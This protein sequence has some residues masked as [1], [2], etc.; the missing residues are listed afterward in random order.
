MNN[1]LKLNCPDL[2]SKRLKITQ[3]SK[4]RK[5]QISSNLLALNGFEKG[6]AVVETPLGEGKG[7]TV[8]L[9]GGIPF[10]NTKRIYERS[11]KQRKNNP[12]EVY[13]ETSSK[14]ILDATIPLM[15]EIVHVTITFGRIIVKP[16]L[17]IIAE[18]LNQ[19]ARA[20][21]PFTVF[22]ACSSGVDA[23]AAKSAGFEINSLL[24]Y[25][26]QE[27]RD[28]RDLTET[29]VMCALAN[30]NPKHVFNEDI[31][32]VSTQYLEWATKKD[33][34]SVFTISLQCDDFSS[35]KSLTNRQK[36]ILNLTSTLDMAFDGLRIISAL[37]FP[38]VVLEQVA[39]F[40]STDIARMWD[41][42]LRK[43][44]Y[45]THEII[46]DARDYGGITS[47]NR[48]FHVSTMIPKEFAFSFPE[49]T[50]RR[51]TPIWDEYIAPVLNDLREIT[52]TSSMQKGL[53]CGR[54]RIINS[55]KTYSYSILKSQ[56]RQAKDSLV[57]ADGNRILFPNEALLKSLMSI[58]SDFN[59]NAT[60]AEQ[61]TE[62]IGQAVEYD[63]YKHLMTSIKN[64]IQ[65]YLDSAKSSIKK[66]VEPA[67]AQ[68]M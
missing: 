25:R 56:M 13:F 23:H 5:I 62:I 43:M 63:F 6:T 53:E 22:A 16:M 33:P 15:T 26:P 18:K 37:K 20:M 40:A 39:S 48:Y 9:A 54:L 3:T 47:R 49:M 1:V 55:T 34:S 50:P 61:A 44:G 67:T 4:G 19:L 58:P 38:V 8:E 64:H 52:H 45:Q 2:S 27:S 29:G 42:R 32:E 41:L 60:N 68:A 24:E 11:Y 51:E 65:S 14:K 21:N 31:T 10:K 35:A 28:K 59:L 7:Y 46:A 57:V 12:V 17:N 30:I 36:S 66:I